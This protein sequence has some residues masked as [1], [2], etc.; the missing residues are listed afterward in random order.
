MALFVATAGGVGYA[1][2]AP[3]T[4]GSAAAIP[5]FV[6]LSRLDPLLYSLTVV[7]LVFLGIWAADMT[8]GLFGRKDDGRIVIDEVVGQLIALAPL[9]LGGGPRGA[10]ALVTG[11]VAF[12]LFDIWKPGPVAWAERHFRGGAGVVLDDVAAGLLA[13]LVV[14]ALALAVGQ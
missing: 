8:E 10:T 1:P 14:A 9:A 6:L 5:I 12:R 13:A 7:A 11:F 2:V 4:F 3:G